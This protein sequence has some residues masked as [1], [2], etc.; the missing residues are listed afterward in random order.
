MDRSEAERKVAEEIG[1]LRGLDAIVL[2]RH[3]R[4]LAGR[5]LP[6]HLPSPIVLRMVAYRIQADAFAD[7]DAGTARILNR[8]ATQRSGTDD[9]PTLEA[10]GLSSRNERNLASGAVLVREHDGVNHHV[11]VLQRGFA[12]NGATY[13]SLSEVAR[14]ITGTRWNGHRFFGLDKSRNR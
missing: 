6:D 7:L 13:A 9:K 10:L 1:A 8:I 14:A 3:W 11:M 5:A 4:S 12:W 2:R